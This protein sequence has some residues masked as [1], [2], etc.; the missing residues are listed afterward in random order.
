MNF[1][2]IHPV[3]VTLVAFDA[4]E[5]L[6]AKHSKVARHIRSCVKCQETLR[7]L[8]QVA[9]T[10]KTIAAPAPPAALLSRILAGRASGERVLLPGS[11][12]LHVETERQARRVSAPVAAAAAIAI[13]LTLLVN[14]E[15]SAASGRL[16]HNLVH[17]VGPLRSLVDAQHSDSIDRANAVIPVYALGQVTAETID[18]FQSITSIK[19]FSDGRVL[20]HDQSARTL[21]L[22]DSTLMSSTLIAGNDSGA[23][24]Y[25][26]GPSILIPFWG[27]SVLFLDAASQSVL[28]MNADG[29]VGRAI[30]L[31]AGSDAVDLLSGQPALD[32][33]GR[34]YYRLPSGAASPDSAGIVRVNLKAKTVDTIAR[35]AT[36]GIK[37]DDW[38]VLADGTVAIVRGRDYGIDWIR[39]DGS[40]ESSVG[41]AARR[42]IPDSEPSVRVGARRADLRGNVWVQ[43]ADPGYAVNGGSLYDDISRNGAITRRVLMK[44]GYS[45]A[46]FGPRGTVY[47]LITDSMGHRLAR[48]KVGAVPLSP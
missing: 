13:A 20:V 44:R 42:V 4:G 24:R 3:M 32:P 29:A 25:G 37:R 26:A 28:V 22:Y 43:P 39:P 12:S 47:V 46:G 1:F 21:R 41:I 48:A 14:P 27:D 33:R 9:A 40:Y 31:P 23:M 15:V 7:F 8:R 18:D 10:S 19:A 45:V 36:S 16:M 34:L 30:S 17:R 6:P 35:L 5:L 2:L 11:A 38:A